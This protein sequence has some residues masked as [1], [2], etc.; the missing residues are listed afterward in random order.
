MT[1]CREGVFMMK[2]SKSFIAV[3]LIISICLVLV[4]GCQQ[5]AGVNQEKQS[6]M[7]DT[8]VEK[9]EE[10]KEVNDS[11]N[12]E[13]AKEEPVV[14][15]IGHPKS[16]T[17]LDYE[18]NFMTLSLEKEG[19]FDLQFIEC[20]A[21]NEE[22]K[23]KIELQIMA[24][25]DDLPD[26]LCYTLDDNSVQYYGSL[27]AFIPLNDYLEN[28]AYH[29]KKALEDMPFDPFLYATSPDGNIYGLF[30]L[31]TA[32]ETAYYLRLYL[33]M[34]WVEALGKEIP[35]S[36]QEFEDL[37]RAFVNEDPNG[38]GK[39]DEYGFLTS[40]TRIWNHFVMPLMTPF[41]YAVGQG[42]NNYLIF[43]EDGTI[44]AAYATEGWREGLRWL[45]RLTTE[46]LIS[47]LS[48]TLDEAQVKTIA[49]AQDEHV[50]GCT[51]YYPV[52]WYPTGDERTVNWACIP[53]MA[54]PD[55]N[56]VAPYAPEMPTMSF[57]ITKNCKNPEAAFRLGDMLMSEKYTIM[58]RY[59]EEGVDWVHAKPDDVSYVEGYEAK[60][61]P[62]LAWAIPQNKRW[63]NLGCWMRTPTIANGAAVKG[64]LTGLDAWANEMAAQCIPYTDKSKVVGKIIYTLEEEEILSEIRTNITT[65]FQECFVRFVVGDMD[66]DDDWDAYLKELEDMGLN[67][68]L[69]IAQNA[70]NRMHKK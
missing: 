59:G 7:A 63:D 12:N 65:Y 23:Q 2:K 34:D 18:T 30:H 70:Y 28:N 32:I 26:I 31:S 11:K 69:E 36:T 3:F 48:F 20:G 6:E 13:V 5:K 50:I 62:I 68:Y 19:N 54:G 44:G 22:M 57:F 60:I 66:L 24:G 35:S 53:C 29:I 16:T 46:G 61:I 27:G 15:T 1:K 8:T 37:L 41:V 55:G 67:E 42:G 49:N 14:L 25:G 40:K 47:P 43:N 64:K 39:K 52:S 51:T 17:V 56:R 21:N 38:N 9:Q 10:G 4:S 33:N 58:T 45:N